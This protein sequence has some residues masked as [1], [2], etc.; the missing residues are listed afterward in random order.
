MDEEVAR[1]AEEL[2]IRNG[3]MESEEGIEKGEK[4]VIYLEK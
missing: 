4:K 3:E 2:K 1:R